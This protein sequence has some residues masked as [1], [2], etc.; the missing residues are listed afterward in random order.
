LQQV[1]TSHDV[2]HLAIRKRLFVNTA[3]TKFLL[4]L[5]AKILVMAAVVQAVRIALVVP[6]RHRAP[7]LMRMLSWQ[8]QQRQGVMS[9]SMRGRANAPLRS[10]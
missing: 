5:T 6:A 10:W 7:A 4:P 9:F 8:L 3:C 2:H 1:K